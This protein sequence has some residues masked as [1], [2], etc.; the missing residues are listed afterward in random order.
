MSTDSVKKAVLIVEDDSMLQKALKEKLSR[1]GFL[2]LCA[3]NGEEGLKMALEHHPDI[4]IVDILM[5]V[6]DGLTMLNKLREDI[7]GKNA[8]VIV[9]TNLDDSQHVSNAMN[10]KLLRYIVKSDTTLDSIVEEI[11]TLLK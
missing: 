2:V 8:N 10:Q 11:R 1:E 6:M 7:W 4:V 9:L 3:G 5:P